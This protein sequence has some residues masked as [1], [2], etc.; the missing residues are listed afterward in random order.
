MRRLFLKIFLW[1]LLAMVLV[2]ATLLLSAAM[3]Q[4]NRPFAPL[5]GVRGPLRAQIAAKIFEREGNEMLAEYLQTLEYGVHTQAYLF[6]EDGAEALGR[7]TPPGART[8]AGLAGRSGQLEMEL[9]GSERF[10]A[11]PGAGPSGHM[12]VLVLAAE[13]PLGGV[14]AWRYEPLVGP[15]PLLAVLIMAG[16]LCFWL[17]RHITIPVSKM[18]TTAQQ[19]A[20]GNLGARVGRAVAS[21][22]DELADL[23]RNFDRMAERLESLLTSQRLLFRNVSHEL[24]SPLARLNVALELARQSAAAE[25]PGYLDRIEREAERLNRLIGQM[26]TLARLESGMDPAQQGVFD[27]GGLVQEVVADGD[28]EARARHSA[29]RMVSRETC[30]IFGAAELLR[31]A[32]EN[33][34]RNAVHST[35]EGTETEVS[36]SH[37]AAPEGAHAV[38]EVRDHGPGVPEK[39]LANIFHPF[40]RLGPV[41]ERHTGGTGLG[42]A[43]AER[44]VRIHGGT[45]AAANAPGGGLLMTICIPTVPTS[46]SPGEGEATIED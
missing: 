11:I 6:L 10:W 17:A 37:R 33:V 36:V 2:I 18:R 40:Y 8:L 25:V 27:L 4:S 42:L 12:Y 38:I 32:M 30:V 43:I 22:H 26:L 14:M 13:L 9:A 3:A 44:A 34:V 29:V 21:R 35:M 19:L 7:A 31:S 5:R 15:V 24:R 16:V 45:I 41:H 1:F 46:S 28:F 23:G 39:E 20:D